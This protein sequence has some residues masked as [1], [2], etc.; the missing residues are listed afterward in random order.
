MD[1][2]GRRGRAKAGVPAVPVPEIEDSD[3]SEEDVAFVR[4]HR[5]SAFL[6]STTTLVE[7]APCVPWLG[8][9]CSPLTHPVSVWQALQA[10]R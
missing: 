6:K 5:A 4:Q 8:P 7:D 2:A 9:A 3:L 10:S 1:S